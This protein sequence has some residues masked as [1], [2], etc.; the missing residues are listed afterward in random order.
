MEVRS[1]PGDKR[2]C[3]ADKKLTNDVDTHSSSS[4][5]VTLSPAKEILREL[6]AKEEIRIFED[7]DSW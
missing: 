4:E 2:F 1:I 7:C 5:K 6:D 3:H